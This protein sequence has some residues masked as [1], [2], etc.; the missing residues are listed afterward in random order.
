MH[1]PASPRK[2]Q[3]RRK[4][5]KQQTIEKK[6]IYTISRNYYC[7]YN[8]PDWYLLATVLVLYK[9]IFI[10][11]WRC[12]WI[13]TCVSILDVVVPLSLLPGR[14]HLRSADSGQYDVP[15]TSSSVGSRA[16]SVVGLK[17]WNQL[18]TSVR[19]INCVATFKRHLKTILFTEAYS[20]SPR[21]YLSLIRN[22]C[23]TATIYIV[24]RHCPLLWVALYKSWLWLCDQSWQVTRSVWRRSYVDFT[25]KTREQ[26]WFTD[27]KHESQQQRNMKQ[28]NT[29]Q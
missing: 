8:I 6:W 9:S 15:R 4:T 25:H 5:D 26:Q 14:A 10:S 17:A 20:V 12:F 3:E 2:Q 27:V 24:Q 1:Y 28:S 7:Y 18:P 21:R 19:H 29:R 13:C 23:F 16:F 22:F 11:A